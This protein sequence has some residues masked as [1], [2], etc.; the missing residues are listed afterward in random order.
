M[1][2]PNNGSFVID[3]S[4]VN[5]Q[6][7]NGTHDVEI[8]GAKVKVSQSGNLMINLQLQ[9]VS[10]DSNGITVFD[11]LVFTPKSQYRI[12]EFAKATHTDDLL[13]GMQ[14]TQEN[15]QGYADHIL[16]EALSI[17]TELR[18]S[19]GTDK[20][21][22]PYGPQANVVRYLEYGSASAGAT[23]LDADEEGNDPF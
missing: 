21:G 6:A 23:I 13:N 19:T 18:D 4:T 2:N 3:F 15:L 17:I 11:R 7:Q 10:E 12:M 14:V 16:G 22:K 1:T 8:K 20:D 5:Q 9:I